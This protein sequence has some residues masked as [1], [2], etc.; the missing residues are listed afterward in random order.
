MVSLPLGFIKLGLVYVWY[1]WPIAEVIS[2][3]AS[4]FILQRV[5]KTRLQYLDAREISEEMPLE[6]VEEL[7]VEE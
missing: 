7:I 5:Y 2:L 3:L 6:A 1:A 4:I